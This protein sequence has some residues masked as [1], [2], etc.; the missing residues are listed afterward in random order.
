[1]AIEPLILWRAMPALLIVLALGLIVLHRIH[2]LPV[3][4]L[5]SSLTD[6][7]APAISALSAPLSATMNA[8]DNMTGLRDMKAENI[9]LREENIKLQLWYETGL[10]LQAENKSLR[11]LLNVKADPAFSFISARVISDVGGSFVKSVL[12]PVGATDKVTKGSAVLSGHS[13]V[14][15]V[16][17]VGGRS[18]RV[19]LVTDLNSRIPV[20]IQNTRTRA[21]LAGKN[22]DLLRLERLPLDS[23]ITVGARVVTSGDGGQLPADLP[24]GTIVQSD[25]TGVWVKPLSDLDRLIYVQ[26]VNAGLDPALS[27]G[28]ILPKPA[29]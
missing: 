27:T 6:A 22:K 14:G 9:R 7:I 5:R 12:L 28:E 10:R 23:G 13:L 16:M 1:M 20:L 2:A 26:V 3:E 17:E 29:K 11:E 25:A 4:K 21:I 24:I 18:S 8:A 19:L 15:R